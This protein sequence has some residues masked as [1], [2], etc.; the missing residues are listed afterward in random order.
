M[1]QVQ[2]TS[3]WGGQYIGQPRVWH[4]FTEANKSRRAAHGMS[5]ATRA[6]DESHKKKMRNAKAMNKN[7]A[8]QVS[9]IR[10]FTNVNWLAQW[11]KEAQQQQ[12]TPHAPGRFPCVSMSYCGARVSRRIPNDG[13]HPHLRKMVYRLPSTNTTVA[14][15]SSPDQQVERHVTRDH[16]GKRSSSA[17]HTN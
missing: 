4:D 17:G 8:E 12:Q 10:C 13:Q 1:K 9:I 6:V 3:T 14:R 5:K 11:R 2:N 15:N 16:R 7:W